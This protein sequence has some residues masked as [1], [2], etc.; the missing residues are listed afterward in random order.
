MINRQNQ[1]SHRIDSDRRDWIEKGLR[2]RSPLGWALWAGEE[3]G[4]DF[5]KQYHISSIPHIIVPDRNGAFV[6]YLPR[7]PA[8]EINWRT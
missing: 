4:D 3:P 7:H 1:V 6:K 2:K 8:M 5:Q